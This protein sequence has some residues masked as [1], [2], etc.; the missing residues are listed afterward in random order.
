MASADTALDRESL[1]DLEGVR[2]AVE[3]GTPGAA[4]WRN[5]VEAKLR[6]AGI[7]VLDSGES[8]TGDPFLRLRVAT[9][10][11]NGGLIGYLVELDFAQ[12]V[13]L[14]RNPAVTF[15]RAQ[16]WKAVERLG[17]IPPSR[18]AQKINQELSDQVDQFIRAYLAVN[19][20]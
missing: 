7:K 6:S 19:P 15:N 17:V 8:P 10:S 18:L 13:F 11:A 12:I 9:T 5:A 3:E 1:R 2:V 20:K 16:T 4:E 14:S